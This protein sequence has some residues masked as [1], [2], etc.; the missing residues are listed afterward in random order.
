MTK[1]SNKNAYGEPFLCCPNCK[2]TNV[3][4][5]D[6]SLFE[7]NTGNMWCNTVRS[8]DYDTKVNC[9]DCE[10]TG[11]RGELVNEATGKEIK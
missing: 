7:V 2:S 1:K 9:R 8:T 11:I 10:W 4:A 5:E 6:I 3:L